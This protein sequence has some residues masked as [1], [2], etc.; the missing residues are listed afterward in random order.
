[1]E[2]GRYVA[3]RRRGEVQKMG[4][5]VGDPDATP[6]PLLGTSDSNGVKDVLAHRMS[7]CMRRLSL[8]E[9]DECSPSLRRDINTLQ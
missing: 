4:D 5:D 2:N 6:P 9:V 3:F 8:V 1:M 7:A